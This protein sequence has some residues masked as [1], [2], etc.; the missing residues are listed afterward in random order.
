VPK[1]HIVAV[2]HYIQ[3]NLFEEQGHFLVYGDLALSILFDVFFVNVHH[4]D[5]LVNKSNY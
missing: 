3:F 4:L 1:D 5:R 2:D